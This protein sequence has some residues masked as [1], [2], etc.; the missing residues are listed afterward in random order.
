MPLLFVAKADWMGSLLCLLGVML[1]VTAGNK[2]S[3]TYS[4][5]SILDLCSKCA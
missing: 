5:D 2:D 4:L 1:V 3:A